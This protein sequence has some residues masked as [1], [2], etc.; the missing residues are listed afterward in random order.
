MRSINVPVMILLMTAAAHGALAAD[1]AQLLPLSEPG[2]YEVSFH[3][4]RYLDAGRGGREV[5]VTVWYPIAR[6][7]GDAP[8]DPRTASLHIKRDAEPDR[9]GAPYPLILSSTKVAD[10]LAPYLVTRGFAWVSVD[11]IDSYGEMNTEMIDQPRD[12][13]FALDQ[14]ASRPPEGL[15]GLIDTE[16]AGAIGY[17]FDGYNALAMSGARIDPA[18]YLAQCPTPDATTAAVISRFLS[19]F[20]CAPAA[21]WDEF[22]AHAGKALTMSEDGLWR[23]MT[24]RRIRAVMPM[25]A[26][27]WWLFGSRGLAAA[28]RPILMI[29]GT[30]DELYAENALIFER[31]GTA[32]KSLISFVGRNHMMIYDGESIARMAHFAAAFFGFHLQGRTELAMYYSQDFVLRYNDLAWGVYREE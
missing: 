17:S 8:I 16:R 7:A 1:G 29:A 25:A 23:P 12:I 10:I 27:G 13:L 9:S 2:P 19:A 15:D 6:P 21:R 32:T 24:D 14:T 30:R 5:A 31:L 3:T 18:Y 20:S 26:E 4:A 22:V 11:R 28:D